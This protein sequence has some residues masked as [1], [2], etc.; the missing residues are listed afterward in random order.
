MTTLTISGAI[1]QIQTIALSLAGMAAAPAYPL[2][3]FNEFPFA[4][5]FQGPSTHFGGSA[6]ASQLVTLITEVHVTRTNLPVDIARVASFGDTFPAAVWADPTLAATVTTVNAVR[7]SGLRQL[8]YGD[9][10]TIGFRFEI[11]VKQVL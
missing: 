1:A 8:N 9:M 7:C 3:T 5:T 4:V 11:D 10:K 6:M 2:E